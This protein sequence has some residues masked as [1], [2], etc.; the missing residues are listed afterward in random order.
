[1]P[2]AAQTADALPA[3][4]GRIR[5]EVAPSSWRD[6]GGAG[7][8]YFDPPSQCLIVLQTQSGQM[9]VERLLSAR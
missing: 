8:L 2:Q 5:Q 7:Q 9:A 6:A 1:L 3:L 4:L